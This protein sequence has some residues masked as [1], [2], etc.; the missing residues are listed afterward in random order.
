MDD[1]ATRKTLKNKH[2]KY[3]RRISP[4]RSKKNSERVTGR[5]FDS[6]KKMNSINCRIIYSKK[7]SDDHY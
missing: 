1:E 7:Q 2:K 6:D 4:Q 5:R 3:R